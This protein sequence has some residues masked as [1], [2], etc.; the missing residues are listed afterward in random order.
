MSKKNWKKSCGSNLAFKQ[1]I[2]VY[3]VQ[4][5]TMVVPLQLFKRVNFFWDTRFIIHCLQRINCS[6]I[7]NILKSGFPQL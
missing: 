5:E 3:I 7:T 6:Q 2:A 4:N 1:V